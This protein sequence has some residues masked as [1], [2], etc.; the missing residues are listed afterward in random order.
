[1]TSKVGERC[2]SCGQII[3][4]P[5]PYNQ[6]A[7]VQAFLERQSSDWI[8]SSEIAFMLDWPREVVWKVMNE[9]HKQGK[10]MKSGTRSIG[11]SWKYLG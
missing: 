1:M 4:K 5:R 7:T 10:I 8:T 3:T 11:Y 6:V 9:L 2:H